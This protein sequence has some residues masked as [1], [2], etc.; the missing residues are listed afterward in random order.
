MLFRKPGVANPVAHIRAIK[1]YL[2]DVSNDNVQLQTQTTGSTHE[3][4]LIC[5]KCN[6]SLD[7]PIELLLKPFS[8][9]SELETELQWAQDH[10]HPPTAAEPK[11]E[12][13]KLVKLDSERKLKIVN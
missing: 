1:K 12:P 2:T 3:A 8:E 4:R 9:D 10:V 13:V 11:P 6:R 5:T 7:L